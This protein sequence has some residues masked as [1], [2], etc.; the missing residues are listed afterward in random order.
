MD[1]RAASALTLSPGGFGFQRPVRRS[2]ALAA[3][4]GDGGA[5]APPLTRLATCTPCILQAGLLVSG[6]WM[7]MVLT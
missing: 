1:P 5:G 7:A 4:G 2:G 3:E 6:A